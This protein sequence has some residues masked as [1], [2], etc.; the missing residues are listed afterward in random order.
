MEEPHDGRIV[1]GERDELLG[2][3]NGDVEVTGVPVESHE[4]HQ[5]VTIFGMAGVG[6]FQLPE[7][8]AP[9][10]HRDTPTIRAHNLKEPKE[11]D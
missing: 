6:A 1:P 11:D 2:V 7:G 9:L 3:L 5:D 4:R 10:A 8:P